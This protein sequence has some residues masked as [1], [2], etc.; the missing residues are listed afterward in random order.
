MAVNIEGQAVNPEQP[1][2]PKEQNTR[3]PPENQGQETK[4]YRRYLPN[5]GI[6]NVIGAGIDAGAVYDKIFT[7]IEAVVKSANA[8]VKDGQVFNAFKLMKNLAGLNYSGIVL[9]ET[10]EG[11]VSAHILLIEKT[12]NYPESIIENIAGS[13]I[14]IIRTP[15]DALDEKYVSSAVKLVSDNTRIPEDQ[16]IVTDGTLVPNEFDVNNEGALG[17]LISNTFLAIH[18]ENIIQIEGYTGFNLAGLME[19]NPKGKFIVNLHFNKQ[20]AQYVNKAMMPIRQDICVELSYKANQGNSYRGVNQGSD[21]SDVIKVYGYI[22]F[23]FA[24]TPDLRSGLLPSQKFIPNF[25]ITGFDTDQAPTPDLLLLGISSIL[26]LNQEFRW[27]QMFKS[28][29]SKKSEIDFNDIGALNIEANAELDVSG[30]GKMYQTKTNKFDILELNTLVNHLVR[31]SMMVSIDLPKAGPDTWYLSIFYNGK[32]KDNVRAN[33]RIIDSLMTLTS[34]NYVNDTPIFTD[35]VN[36]IHGGYYRTKDGYADLR[37]LSSY[38]SVSNYFNST[39]QNPSRISEYTDTMT[40]FNIP[41]EIR[42]SKRLDI[43]KEISGNTVT[44]K[45]FYNRLTFSGKFLMNLINSLNMSSFSPIFHNSSIDSE[46]FHRRSMLDVS[47]ATF[48][49]DLRIM[50]VND[51]YRNYGAEDTF[52]TR[53]W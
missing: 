2:Q 25:V 46:V 41:S 5:F 39:G 42:A 47:G 50:G 30:Y 33:E 3:R 28:T 21:V 17:A 51:I 9:T 23:E 1:E 38:L 26:S 53:R 29:P 48:G 11:K 16:I 32:M 34:R 24:G 12:G 37:Q 27:M 19:S 36:R 18:S 44:V 20:N 15:A 6:K 43:V 45:Q 35:I 10:R 13:K 31:P 22:D 7:E 14:E 8:S 40:N 49:Q 4:S 52:Y